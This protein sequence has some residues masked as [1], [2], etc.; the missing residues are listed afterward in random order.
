MSID[1]HSPESISNQLRLWLTDMDYRVTVPEA[2]TYPTVD[3]ALEVHERGLDAQGNKVVGLGVLVSQPK[4]KHDQIMIRGHYALS[5]S[6]K[7]AFL[8]LPDHRKARILHE[9]RLKFYGTG[10]RVGESEE[11]TSFDCVYIIYY[12]GLTKNQLASIVHQ[13]LDAFRCIFETMRYY[14]RSD[15]LS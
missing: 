10:V 4:D 5:G 6:D 3:W 13:V 8:G 2:G 12:D 14:I 11:S 7:T 9:I 1:I 15:E